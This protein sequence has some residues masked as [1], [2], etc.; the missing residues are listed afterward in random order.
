MSS[1]RD[2]YTHAASPF[3]KAVLH[4]EG[5]ISQLNATMSFDI[6]LEQIIKLII[7]WKEKNVR[8]VLCS[9]ICTSIS[10]APFKI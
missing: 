5:L 2:M 4:P 6:C 10:D 7:M 8:F 3:H 9:F 1:D